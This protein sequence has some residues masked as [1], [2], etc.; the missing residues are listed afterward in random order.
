MRRRE[1]S[2]GEGR[3]PHTQRGKVR[4]Q[5]SHATPTPHSRPATGFRSFTSE[6]GQ[7]TIKPINPALKSCLWTLLCPCPVPKCLSFPLCETEQRDEAGMRSGL[8]SDPQVPGLR[9]A[10]SPNSWGDP[11]TPGDDT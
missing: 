3:P 8:S 9:P 4:P 10:V 5:G 6:K 7:R 1:V 11:S 2:A